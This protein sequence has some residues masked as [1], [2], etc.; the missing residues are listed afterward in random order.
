MNQKGWFI[1]NWIRDVYWSEFRSTE[2][3]SSIPIK[4]IAEYVQVM[5]EDFGQNKTSI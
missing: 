5:V 3:V 2:L 1:G 4:H